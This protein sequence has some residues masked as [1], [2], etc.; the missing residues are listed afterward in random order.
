MTSVGT[1]LPPLCGVIG[2]RHLPLPT[3]H[4]ARFPTGRYTNP[5]SSMASTTVV[6]PAMLAPAT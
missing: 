2:R 4:Q 5:W 3:P 1:R 6:K